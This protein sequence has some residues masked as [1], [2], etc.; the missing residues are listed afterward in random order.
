MLNRNDT[1]SHAI[2]LV[3]TVAALGCGVC[4]LEHIAPSTS[5]CWATVGWPQRW[6][7][8]QLS[9]KPDATATPMA[10]SGWA[11]TERRQPL[12]MRTRES[13]R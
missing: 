1:L 4:A 12:S 6:R 11:R 13:F 9:T 2:R 7:R 10:V 8:I 3:P 5:Q